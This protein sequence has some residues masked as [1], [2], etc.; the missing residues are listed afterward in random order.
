MKTILL[1]LAGPLQA[2]G[3]GSH[4]ETRQTDRY[5]SKSA[6]I[7]MIAAS[8]GYSRNETE[9]IQTL[10]K[11]NY[12]ARIDQRGRIL[13]DY[14]IAAKHKK[15]GALDKNYVTNRYY[16][17]DA[18]FVVGIGSDDNV[19]MDSIEKA[20]KSPY[21]QLYLGRKSLPVTADF[22]IGSTEKSVIDSLKA[23]RWEASDWYRKQEDPVLDIYF[24]SD[25][26]DSSNSFMKRDRVITFSRKGRSYG[27]RPVS[28]IQVEIENASKLKEH[29]AFSALGG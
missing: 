9:K 29:D 19:L 16:L 7:G 3:T 24:D 20:L 10:N 14:H 25:L 5:P 21:F 13:R 15:N 22:Y 18:V 6:V 26:V 17:Q 12:A 4:F 2:W 11:L 28:V 23:A 8:L 27:F 1:K